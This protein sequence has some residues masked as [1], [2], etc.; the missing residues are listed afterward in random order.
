MKKQ[1]II[2]RILEFGGSNS[3]LRSLIQY[4]GKENVVIVLK[5]E[6]EIRFAGKIDPTGS[7]SVKFI[8]G[9]RE[10]VQFK[11]YAFIHNLKEVYYALKSFYRIFKLSAGNG[12]AR[13]SV[14]VIDPESYLYLFWC[15]F[16]DVKYI[17][18][19]KPGIIRNSCTVSTCN[20]RLGPNREIITVSQSNK[21]SVITQWK[22][23]KQKEQYV[24]VVYNCVV[25]NEK[26]VSDVLLFPG[27]RVIVTMGHVAYYK[28]PAL[29]LK[30]ARRVTE[31]RKDVFFYWLGNGDL[32][33]E[34]SNQ[35]SSVEN[36]NFVGLI[37]N[38]A[39]YLKNATIYYQPSIM[40]TQGIAVM[41]AMSNSLPCIVSNVGGLPESIENNKNG[42]VVDAHNEDEHVERMLELLDN[43]DLQK[44]FG[45]Y[46]IKK[47]NQLF[48]YDVFKKKMDVIYG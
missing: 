4:F 11:K 7:L 2:T 35:T 28:N 24:K 30:V 19:T 21:E 38:P 3:Y 27:G 25:V 39:P 18:H 41:E 48:L 37:E 47:Y 23:S 42:F 34:L 9:L 33:N 20:I 31:I 13:V 8:P 40:E 16:I 5:K 44:S 12:F 15:P 10:F 14:S 43:K 26:K 22:I 45:E 36:I 32:F 1:I 6:E 17:L 46:S 29:W